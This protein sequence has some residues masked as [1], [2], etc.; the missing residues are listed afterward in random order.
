MLASSGS[1]RRRPWPP[2]RS[3]ASSVARRRGRRSSALRPPAPASPAS[4]STID[5]AGLAVDDHQLRRPGRCGS[6]SCRP[7]DGRHLERAREDGRVV[8]AAAGVGGKAADLRPVDLRGQRRRELV[9]DEHRRLLDVARAGRAA[10]PRPCRRFIFSRPDQVGD[11]A[12]PL[13]EIRVGHLV[14]DGAELVE[15]PAGPPTRR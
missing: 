3:G 9:G 14:E 6:A 11:V 12:L 15:R 7:D 10:S 8:R 2:A 13:A 4:G 1:G 5:L